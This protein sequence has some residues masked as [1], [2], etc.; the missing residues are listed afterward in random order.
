MFR[1]ISV[2]GAKAAER[3]DYSIDDPALKDAVPDRKENSIS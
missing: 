1:S 3:T 2:G